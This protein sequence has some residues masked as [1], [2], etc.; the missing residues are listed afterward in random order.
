MVYRTS[1]TWRGL[2]RG[3]EMS[4][5][6]CVLVSLPL[7]NTTGHLWPYDGITTTPTWAHI[8][9]IIG[10]TANVDM[11][12]FYDIMLIGVALLC[13][14]FA[15]VGGMTGAFLRQ[16]CQFGR[17]VFATVLRMTSA[18]LQIACQIGQLARATPAMMWGL[19]TYGAVLQGAAAKRPPNDAQNA[20]A[21]QAPTPPVYRSSA[22]LL[23]MLAMLVPCLLS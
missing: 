1:R 13:R 7:P 4:A 20:T 11:A 21:C 14:G 3:D 17:L 6:L 12:V 16:A 19:V 23:A 9:A 2:L 15:Q 22:I 10:V 18:I 8:V 5:I